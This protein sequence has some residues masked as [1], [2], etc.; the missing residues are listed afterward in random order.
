MLAALCWRRERLNSGQL[1]WSGEQW[2]ELG[3]LRSDSSGRSMCS[4]N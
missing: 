1:V 4:G 3:R 2:H